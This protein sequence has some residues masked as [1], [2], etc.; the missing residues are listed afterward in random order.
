VS[1]LI[2]PKH[3]TDTEAVELIH[4]PPRNILA[5][6]DMRKY[7][8]WMA[9][10]MCELRGSLIGAEMGLGKTGASILAMTRM[11]DAGYIHRP[12]VIAPL[13]VAE[14]TWPDEFRT[15]SFGRDVPF[16]VV[17]GTAEERMAALEYPAVVTIINRENLRWLHELYDNRPWPFDSIWYDEVS[18]LKQGLIRVKQSKE[19]RKKGIKAGFTELGIIQARRA[20]TKRF[21]GLSGTPAPNGLIDLWGPIF[22]CD[23]GQ[24][25]GTS[26]TAY[27]QRWFKEDKYD[28]S[29]TAFPHSEREIMSKIGDVFFSLRAEDY[30]KLPKLI[31]VDHKVKL[32]PKARAIYREMEREMGIEM[33]NRAGDPVF[34]EAVNNGVLVNKLLQLCN[35]SIYDET[36]EDIPV[37]TAKIDV[38]ES[39]MEEASG[40][41][42]LVGYSFQFDKNIIRK[43]FPYVRILGESASDIRDWN[44]GEIRMLLTHPASAGHGLNLQH[45]S[46]I[47][48]WYGL[49]WSLELYL[50]FLKRLHRPGQTASRVFLHHIIAED[51]VD[52]N[53]VEL[54]GRKGATQDQITDVVRVR[55]AA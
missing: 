22:A 44:D 41:P 31:P 50:Q 7:Q 49:T 23:A 29:I 20:Q 47:A 2:L 26:I 34:I 13:Y 52:E 27:K 42:V 45:G 51:T 43:K 54:W 46:N 37:H 32:P 17:T 5:E 16:R 11:L 19:T 40:K 36:K 48:V 18:R 15:W 55:L 53:V 30:I 12:L 4:G 39:I 10:K 3:L 25:L 24:R 21:I 28:Y 1:K 33:K 8:L 38:L 9:E 6:S 35:G 14:W